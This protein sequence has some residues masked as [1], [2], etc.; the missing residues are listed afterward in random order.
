M[1]VQRMDDSLGFFGATVDTKAGT[2]TV[3][4]GNDKNGKSVFR[5]QRS[6]Q[7]QLTLDGDMDGHKL[8]FQLKRMDHN[9]LELISR[10]FHWIQEYPYNR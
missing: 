2:I 4:R 1:A 9:E 10:G 6:G 8:H 3:T 7:D 5:Y